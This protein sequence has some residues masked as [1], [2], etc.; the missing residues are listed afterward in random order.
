MDDDVIGVIDGEDSAQTRQQRRL[1]WSGGLADELLD[2][3]FGEVDVNDLPSRVDASVGAP[4]N[5][6]GHLGAGDPGQPGL[7]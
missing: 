6:G 7:Q 4:G 2:A 3:L 5:D 1:G